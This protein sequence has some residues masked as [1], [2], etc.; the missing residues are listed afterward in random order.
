MTT[1]I[2]CLAALAVAGLGVGCAGHT[3][4]DPFLVPQDRIYGS[5]RTIAVTPIGTPNDLSS[6]DPAR[7]KFDSL[8]TAELR[9]AGF[10]VVPPDESA[11]IWKRV[12]DS[13]GGLYSVATGER[14]TIKQKVARAVTMA[15]LRTRFQ[16]DAWLHLQ[17]V[18][19][20]AKFDRGDAQWD[21]AKQSYQSFGKKFLTAL[22]GG[23]TYGKTAAL[24]VSVELEDMLGKDLYVNQGGLQLYMVPSGQEW[25]TIPSRELY[26][27]PARN[28][29][30]VRLALAPLVTRAANPKSQ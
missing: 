14:D 20:S 8:I 2:T 22:F 18:I 6:V 29:N 28:A 4:Y 11:A 21:G 30:A 1:R 27:D 24:S 16:A 5:V 13:L 7:G 17:I 26:G 19:A 15:E 12:T 23:G 25:V 10:T 3:R 9:A